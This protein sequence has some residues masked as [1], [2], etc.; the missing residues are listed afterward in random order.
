MVRVEIFA[1]MREFKDPIDDACTG[2]SCTRIICILQKLRQNMSG[3]L[4]LFE[5]L[6]P[7]TR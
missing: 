6:M 2:F 3:A 1:V 7:W 4:N 5:Q